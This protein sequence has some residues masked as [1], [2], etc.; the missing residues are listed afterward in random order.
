MPIWEDFDN[1]TLFCVDDLLL[2]EPTGGS[3]IP[4]GLDCLIPLGGGAL[5]L[6]PVRPCGGVK[7]DILAVLIVAVR[8]PSFLYG[9]LADWGDP[10]AT[11]VDKEDRGV[12]RCFGEIV[13][14]G[15]GVM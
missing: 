7:Y 14:A 8:S 5:Y 13:L 15:E 3:T 12:W 1:I 10:F 11:T 4:G 2:G 9:E 6:M